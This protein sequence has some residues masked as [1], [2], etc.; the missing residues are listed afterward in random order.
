MYLIGLFRYLI[1][2]LTWVSAKLQSQ[3]VH[4]FRCIVTSFCTIRL[5]DY[6]T[7]DQL[8]VRCL[9]DKTN[10]L[11]F[12]LRLYDNTRRLSHLWPNTHALFVQYNSSIISPLT[13]YACLCV[14]AIRVQ[15]YISLYIFLLGKTIYKDPACHSRREILYTKASSQTFQH[16]SVATKTYGNAIDVSLVLVF[17]R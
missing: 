7:F 6:L 12:F 13:T 14:C 4:L 17:I 8:H 16:G 3:N 10:R 2:S 9:Y 5:I 1:M 15:S 11:S